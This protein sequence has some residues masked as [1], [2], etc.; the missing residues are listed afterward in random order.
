MLWWAKSLQAEIDAAKAVRCLLS[1]EPRGKAFGHGTHWV[2]PMS[3]WA[4]H[5]AGLVKGSTELDQSPLFLLLILTILIRL[6]ESTRV[7]A[8][9]LRNTS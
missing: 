7:S 6:I 9:S 8:G 4:F 2:S 3:R 1:H 5:N